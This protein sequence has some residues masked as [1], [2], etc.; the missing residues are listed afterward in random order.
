MTLFSAALVI[1]V[2]LLLGSFLNVVIHR[3]PALWGLAGGDRRARGT[4]AAPRSR[5]PNCGAQIRILD[6]VPV[7]SYVALGGRCRSCRAPI[8]LRYPLV[9]LAGGGACLVSL[10]IYGASPAGAFS[11]AFL[12]AL[13]ALAAIDA[14]T[15]Y[16]PEAITLPAIALGLAAN[17]FGLFASP[18][19]AFIGAA[20]GYAA[21]A[22]ISL[23]YRTLRGREGLGLG[24]AA[25]FA[26][27]GAWAGWPALAPTAFVAAL[28]GLGGAGL[29]ATRTRRPL[30]GM[31]PIAFGPALAAAGALLFL[32]AGA[33]GRG[34]IALD[35]GPLGWPLQ[36]GAR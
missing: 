23:A 17:A 14:E 32:L 13:I 21:F 16:L 33:A 24:D 7:A 4:L 27:I 9:E 25:L 19:A 3:G 8:P 26:A 1:V 10:A 29:A 31:T 34:L 35:L 30:D 11:A 12:L 18:L 2:G 36:G 22:A 6:L 20:A 5:C 28:L 15:G